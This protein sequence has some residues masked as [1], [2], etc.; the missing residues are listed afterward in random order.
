MEPEPA[1]A[2]CLDLTRLARRIG[3]GALTGIDRVELAWARYLLT[4]PGPA[5]GLVRT[6]LGF[7]LLDRSGIRAL[8]SWAEGQEIPKRRDP[9][10]LLRQM[11]GTET[12]RKVEV[13]LSALALAR[14]H[15]LG[16]SRMLAR[17]LPPAVIYLNTGHSNLH[18]RVM[19]AVKRVKGAKIGVLIHDTIPLDHP[20][21][22]RPGTAEAFLEKLRIVSAHADRVFYVSAAS[23]RAAERH[24][25]KLGR[26]PPGQSAP[27]TI[28]PPQPGPLPL[29]LKRAPTS[30]YFVTLGTIEP[31]KDHALL[32]DIWEDLAALGG[33]CPELWIIG[34]RGWQNDEVFQRL[35]RLKA[36][37]SLKILELNDLSDGAALALV[38][39]ARALL[40][41]SR[42][43]GFGLP[44]LEAMALGTPVLACD[45]EAYTETAG[46]Y[47]VYLPP[48]DR[49]S[50]GKM[51]LAMVT[52]PD[53]GRKPA[54][55][56]LGWDQHFNHVLASPWSQV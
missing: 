51:I 9:L 19:R 46:D 39:G 38:K 4:H 56:P 43:E 13:A 40:M 16:L 28:D 22:Q 36:E 20:A 6:T 52:D 44:I 37:G 11:R 21:T 10:W 25:A 12:G 27:I 5:F 2:L 50:W 23:Q 14:C 7:H 41:P 45:L 34:R 15:R 8:T 35:D 54:R 3:R 55:A 1:P 48:G 31:R 26:I 18:L 33:A 32:L 53:L 47:A 17:H 42:A 49:Y 24:F 30:P 29:E